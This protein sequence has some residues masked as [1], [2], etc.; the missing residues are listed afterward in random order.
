MTSPLYVDG[1]KSDCF[2]GSHALSRHGCSAPDCKRAFFHHVLNGMCA[3]GL[4][5]GC[6][7]ASGLSS[8]DIAQRMFVIATCAPFSVLC[9][10]HQS[11]GNFQDFE[12]QSRS[13]L[14]VLRG[15][16]KKLI[17]FTFRPMH[18]CLSG[19]PLSSFED[20]LILCGSHGLTVMGDSNKL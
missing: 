19:I 18:D 17:S 1:Q 5:S 3:Y 10:A 20:I 14:D 16:Q 12:H 11:L 6:A 13:P 9:V 15:Y 2:F 8:M 7:S 4:T